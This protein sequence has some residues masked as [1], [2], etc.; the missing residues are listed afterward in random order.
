[1]KPLDDMDAE[2]LANQLLREFWVHDNQIRY[3]IDPYWIA[4]KKGL[5][6]FEVVDMDSSISGRI[7]IKSGQGLIFINKQ[8]S[9]NRK[10]FTCAHEL[11]HYVD[12]EENGLL[13][14]DFDHIDYRNQ[15]S[16]LGTAVN[17]VFANQFAAN[18]LMPTQHF[19]EAYQQLKGDSV[20]LSSWFRVSS[21]SFHFR[22]RNLENEGKL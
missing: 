21:E 22:R 12:Y 6:V 4:T 8:H 20:R 17:E 3:P 7:E 18:L 9:I 14:E 16:S 19:I 13:S 11:G 5:R 10:R 15:I 1:M 2:R